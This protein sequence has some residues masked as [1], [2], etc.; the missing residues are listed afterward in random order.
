MEQVKHFHFFFLSIFLFFAIFN[1]PL[2]SGFSFTIFTAILSLFYCIVNWKI[3]LRIISDKK[4]KQ[5]LAKFVLFLAYS[6]FLVLVL[7]IF[8]SNEDII[9]NEISL[10]TNYFSLFLLSVAIIVYCSKRQ[11]LLKTLVKSYVFAGGY[12]TVL[13]ILALINPGIKAIF[14]SLM[15]NNSSSE[16][17]ARTME[18]VS[19]YRNY[20]L[21]STLF[22]IFGMA[23]STIA[24][25][26]VVLGLQNKKYFVLSAL[27][28]VAAVINAR[29]SFV[30]FLIGVFVVLFRYKRGKSESPV[31][32][33]L[34][35]VVVI[36]IGVYVSFSYILSS[37]N[38]D[39]LIW[40]A[41][42]I[43]DVMSLQTGEKEGYFGALFY[44]FIFFPNDTFSFFW[45]TGLSPMQFMNRN[46]DVGY[47]QYI[48]YYGALGSLI[49]YYAYYN[50]FKISIS[51][52]E[53]PFST[54]L[55]AVGVMVIVYL[56]K[57]TCLGYSMGSVIFVPICLYAIYIRRKN[58]K[59]PI[60][61]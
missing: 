26:A 47:I 45:G 25:F 60:C 35:I 2:Y 22:D 38:S 9:S 8:N 39:Q 36:L 20:G 12:Q 33:K 31:L 51:S 5:T 18:Y 29:T 58:S 56:V 44:E 54:M 50:M 32:K 43:T 53:Q 6:M 30:L 34:G 23:M 27:I 1:P 37:Q 55:K 28:F 46:S 11:Y 19:T 3:F 40:L 52:S 41:T 24:I 7:T 48:W 59:M 49:M 57:L 21:A 61:N 4:I 17:I 42:A 13:S 14:T 10:I 16:K 15:A